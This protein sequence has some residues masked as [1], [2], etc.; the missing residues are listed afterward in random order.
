MDDGLEKKLQ[1]FN[2]HG[3]ISIDREFF[4]ENMQHIP[5]EN[6]AYLWIK[7]EKPNQLV[8]VGSGY[9]GFIPE[10]A[11]KVSSDDIELISENH[12]VDFLYKL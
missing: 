1:K 6:I 11:K 9:S 2:T 5:S 8:I 10:Y 4:L 3:V 7:K 12:S